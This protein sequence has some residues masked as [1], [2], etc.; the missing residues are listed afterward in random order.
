VPLFQ[1]KNRQI[2]KHLEEQTRKAQDIKVGPLNKDEV[3]KY[4][5]KVG[6]DHKGDLQSYMYGKGSTKSVE[7]KI[8]LVALAAAC[9]GCPVPETPVFAEVGGK[10]TCTGLKNNL[11][12]A[13]LGPKELK[14]DGRDLLATKPIVFLGMTGYKWERALEVTAEV[15]VKTPSIPGMPDLQGGGW[16]DKKPEVSSGS[17]AELC[18]FDLS[19]KASIQAKAGLSGERLYVSD[20]CPTY[21]KRYGTKETGSTMK[22]ISEHLCSVLEHGDKKEIIK[23]DALAFLQGHGKKQ[24]RS[25][26]KKYITG[27]QVATDT[28]LQ[29]L[30]ELLPSLKDNANS[31]A[32]LQHHVRALTDYKAQNVCGPYTFVSL[33]GVKPEASAGMSAQANASAKVGVGVGGAG[34]E[35]NVTVTGPSVATSLKFTYYRVQIATA[36]ENRGGGGGKLVRQ[37]AKRDLLAAAPSQYIIMSQDTKITYGQIDFTAIGIS[38]KIELGAKQTLVDVKNPE[39]QTGGEKKLLEKQKKGLF[40][41]PMDYEGSVTG[42]AKLG[43]QE[44]ALGISGE[45]KLKKALNYMFYET[46]IAYWIPP[47]DPGTRKAEE[48]PVALA[49]GSGF[50]FGQSVDLENL[51]E[52]IQAFAKGKGSPA[53]FEG[54]AGALGVGLGQ[55]MKFMNQQKEL[56]SL[57][58]EA[59]ENDPRQPKPTAFLLESSFAPPLPSYVVPAKW[60]NERWILGPFHL[61]WTL[62]DVLIPKKVK[63]KSDLQAIRLRYRISDEKRDDKTRFTLG[64]KYIVTLGIEYKS[65]ELAGSEGIVNLATVWFNKFDKYNKIDDQTAAYDAAVPQVALLHQ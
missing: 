36:A 5:M 10:V 1:N 16:S 32:L 39:L 38:G 50:A 3:C 13:Y 6:M 15:G 2:G 52:Q 46:A 20:P 27:G 18:S 30:A 24:E 65:V 48:R 26:I 28:L 53:Y 33:W 58:A 63:P 43:L 41:G 49:P 8:D 42:K 29:A 4:F 14:A 35:A 9:A 64:F 19:A 7:L 60:A 22:E 12:V 25:W 40:G 51:H 62:R 23:Q 55:L 61:G 56:I 34:F 37:N 54:L 21:L 45:A 57:L 17:Y 31:L 44:T 47:A 11:V 59:P